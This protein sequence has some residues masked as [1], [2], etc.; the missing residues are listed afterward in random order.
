V[1]T[2][3]KNLNKSIKNPWKV[4]RYSRNLLSSSHRDNIEYI[5]N[6]DIVWHTCTPKSASSFWDV[7]CVSVL[8]K[9][10]IKSSYF[11]SLPS[12]GTRPQVNCSYTIKSQIAPFQTLSVSSHQHTL[13]TGDFLAM[14]SSN[15]RIICQTRPILDTLVSLLDFLDDG[16][17]E[18]PWSPVLHMYW[19]KLSFQEKIDEVVEIYLPWHLKYLQSWIL[20]SDNY[21]VKFIFFD[22]V[23][24]NTSKCFNEIFSRWD[25]TLE[26]VN[27]PTLGPINLNKGIRGRGK[28]L[29]PEKTI[30]RIVN[31]VKKTDKLKQSLDDY[32]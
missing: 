6:Q 28:S 10:K 8:N 27:I 16:H 24:E 22:D 23:T 29:L 15:H 2:L 11:N 19:N 18:G 14:L 7:F 4:Y 5:K 26:N 9:K 31:I 32:I 12:W 20:A 13:A 21:D 30:E 1:S 17:T 25:I 3:F